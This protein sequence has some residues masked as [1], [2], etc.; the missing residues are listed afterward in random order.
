MCGMPKLPISLQQIH[1]S[2][3]REPDPS[4][5]PPIAFL[6]LTF[7][8]QEELSLVDRTAYLL[9][10]GW[11]READSLLCF[12]VVASVNAH[13]WVC[14]AP[15]QDVWNIVELRG[16]IYIVPPSR[17]LALPPQ[18]SFQLPFFRRSGKTFGNNSEQGKYY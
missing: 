10:E 12:F 3:V 9:R 8:Q 6:P 14:S 15:A 2:N 13:K 4:A 1:V 18:P 11:G 17:V 5:C 16:K 7:L